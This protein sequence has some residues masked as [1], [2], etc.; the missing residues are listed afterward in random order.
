[1]QHQASVHTTRA[2]HG[3]Q[4]PKSLFESRL[5][6]AYRIQWASEEAAVR[7]VAELAVGFFRQAEAA[8][9]PILGRHSVG[10]LYQR[11]LHLTR[12]EHPWLAVACGT[13]TQTD[14][15]VVLKKAVS[16]QTLHSASAAVQALLTTFRQLL[17]T[18]IGTSLTT[19]LLHNQTH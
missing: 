6:D 11:S 9:A 15:L 10:A 18:L 17:S 16:R 8:L 4:R 19:Q 13:W 2:S 5:N 7:D 1:M 12:S 14:P 3:V